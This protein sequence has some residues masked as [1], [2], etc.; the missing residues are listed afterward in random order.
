MTTKKKSW[1]EKRTSGK[2]PRIETLQKAFADIPAGADMLIPT[3]ELVDGYIRK[4]P[5]GQTS[6]LMEMRKELAALY[7]VPYCCPLTAGIFVRIA[8]EAAIEEWQQ[9]K[10]TGDIAPFWRLL[11][12]ESPAL[13][14]LPAEGLQLWEKMRAKEKLG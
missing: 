2:Q 9:G 3:P 4:I 12:K 14:K 11:S 6:S 8:S 7:E 10:K 13:K 1:V 5:A